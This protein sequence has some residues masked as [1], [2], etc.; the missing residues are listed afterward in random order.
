MITT[1]VLHQGTPRAVEDSGQQRDPYHRDR[2]LC[3]EKRNIVGDQSRPQK[4]Y[5]ADDGGLIIKETNP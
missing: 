5:S 2:E 3:R 4:R 1:A